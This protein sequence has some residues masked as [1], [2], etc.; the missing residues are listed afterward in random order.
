[1]SMEDLTKSLEEE[2]ERIKGIYQKE[3]SELKERL[4]DQEKV[5]KKFQNLNQTIQ[6]KD[7]RIEMLQKSIKQMEAINKEAKDAKE[8]MKQIS[9]DLADKTNLIGVQKEKIT[10]LEA[11]V[12]ELEFKNTSL[13]E[14]YERELQST[15]KIMEE[16]A[17]D[18]HS[19]TMSMS[20]GS[21]DSSSP[22][23]LSYSNKNFI[24][25]MSKPS[26][27][28]FLELDQPNARWILDVQNETNLVERRTAERQARSIAKAG[29]V[30]GGRRLGVNYK[31]EV[32]EKHDLPEK[33]T[34]EQHK[35]MH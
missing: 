26:Q 25:V 23:L 7:K 28:C 31:L 19:R 27:G 1:M 6:E 8:K 29:Y 22:I 33:L 3:I 16:S 35:Y 10:E 9:V 11:R 13:I 14:R 32:V 21:S 24:R 5:E 18:G 15:K 34:R 30:D 2:I 12:K 17:K 4:L 20:S